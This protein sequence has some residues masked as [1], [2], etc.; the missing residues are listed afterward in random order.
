MTQGVVLKLQQ[1]I[2]GF[3]GLYF[4][5]ILF[6]FIVFRIPQMKRVVIE[7]KLYFVLLIEQPALIDANRLI[8]CTVVR[9][10]VGY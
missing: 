7:K 10:L 4:D 1:T 3:H 5:R 6:I 2:G 9:P 8:V